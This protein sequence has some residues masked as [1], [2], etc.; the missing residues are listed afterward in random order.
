MKSNRRLNWLDL[1][2]WAFSDILGKTYSSEDKSH[3][4][5]RMAFDFFHR[6]R[7]A[8]YMVDTIQGLF[9]TGQ[10]YVAE[11]AAGSG[12]VTKELY[13][14][15]YT[16]IRATDLSES[17]LK[18]LEEKLKGIEVKVEN[19]NGEMDGVKD[20]SVDI[21]FQVG[22]T[23]FM[24][25]KGQETYISEAARTLKNGAYVLWPVMWVERPLA[26]TMHGFRSPKTT[27]FA[28][29]SLLSKHGLNVVSAPKLIHGKM[30]LLTT[31]LLVIQKQE[32]S[33]Q[34]SWF[35]AGL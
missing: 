25:R 32:K 21:I 27:S 20:N 26:W 18:V 31:T 10:A 35:S 7:L 23:R 8:K 6:D 2:R 3:F 29:A 15:G 22:A 9:P 24:T 33:Q 1:F 4:Y 14:R 5:D 19:L 16:N 30:G 13:E 11:R 28:I 12:I 34:K 17:Q